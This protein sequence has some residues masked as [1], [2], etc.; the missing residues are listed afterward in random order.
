MDDVNERLC[1]E[2]LAKFFSVLGVSRFGCEV[3]LRLLA[4]GPMPLKTL[5]EIMGVKASQLYYYINELVSRG[6]VEA[7]RGRP[8]VFRAVSVNVID[9]MFLERVSELK[10]TAIEELGK[11]ESSRGM[12]LIEEPA[13]YVNRNWRSFLVRAREIAE[14]ATT[15]LVIGG[16]YLFVN[17]MSSVLERKY[18]EGVMVYVLLYEVPG[19]PINY[20]NLPRVGK[21]RKCV[22]G[23][24]LVVSDSRLAALTQRRGSIAE[25]PV[26]GLIIEE[27]I[28]IDHILQDFF[29]KWIRSNII[30]DELI[31]P[32]SSFTILRLAIYEVQRL[33]ERKCNIKV[34]VYGRYTKSS[35]SCIVEGDLVDTKIDGNRGI[36][37]LVVEVN[38]TI[39]TVGA[40]DAVLE[41]IAASRVE[42]RGVC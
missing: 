6:L 17:Y 26:Y 20:S 30:R 25:N 13:I 3:Y 10:K 33:I 37:Q 12:P 34:I 21:I 5:S 42:F 2:E 15:D 24:I 35:E 22:S 36:A 16:D 28:I 8:S 1:S 40:Q 23:D 19:I 9:G 4:H 18:N 11:I 32:P 7:A 14:K 31:K 29:N 27:P 41:D 38:G 39:Y